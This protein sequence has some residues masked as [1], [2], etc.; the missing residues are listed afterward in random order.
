[1]DLLIGNHV[2]EYVGIDAG[3][4]HNVLCLVLA[5]ICADMPDTFFVTF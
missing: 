2:V 4:V 1:M 3:S 5:V